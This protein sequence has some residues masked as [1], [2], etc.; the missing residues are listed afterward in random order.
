MDFKNWLVVTVALAIVIF[1]GAVEAQVV[2]TKRADPA[3]P[4]AQSSSKAKAQASVELTN[5]GKYEPAT[6]KVHVGDT[7]EWTNKSDSLMW[8]A[9]N[10]HPSHTGLPGFDQRELLRHG[11]SWQFTFNK[12]GRF[13]YHDHLEP[14]RRGTVIVEAK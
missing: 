10:P 1:I 5:K 9:S 8:V 2:T 12:P 11:A 14:S 13:G 3:P 7:V 6:V 4:A